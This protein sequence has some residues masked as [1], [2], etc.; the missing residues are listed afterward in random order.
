MDMEKYF[1][2]K[3]GGRVKDEGVKKGKPSIAE[4]VGMKKKKKKCPK[5]DG[6]GCD[7]CNGKGYTR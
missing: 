1:N 3:K 2:L 4:I 7:K 5:C 6:K